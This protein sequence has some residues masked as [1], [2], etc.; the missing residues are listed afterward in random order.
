METN[1]KIYLAVLTTILV[2][3]LVVGLTLG[4]T[5]HDGIHWHEND[6]VSKND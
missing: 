1:S 6:T 3:G 2:V 4:L 5:E